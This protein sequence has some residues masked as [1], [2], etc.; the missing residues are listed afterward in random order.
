[1]NVQKCAVRGKRSGRQMAV[2]AALLLVL[3][4]IAPAAQAVESAWGSDLYGG[5]FGPAPTGVLSSAVS[6]QVR[7][8]GW[9]PQT[10]TNTK[11]D[12]PGESRV[13]FSNLSVDPKS[14]IPEA[15]FSLT[16]LRT[17][18]F[19]IGYW[20]STQEGRTTLSNAITFDG[21]TFPSSTAVKSTVE[22]SV[23]KLGYEYVLDGEWLRLGFGF[24]ADF[25]STQEQIKQQ[26]GGLQGKLDDSLVVPFVSGEAAVLFAGWEIFA[27]IDLIHYG[28]AYL[29]DGRAGISYGYDL[30]P[31]V[32]TFSIGGGADWRIWDVMVDN[33]KQNAEW[34]QQGLELFVFL[35][36]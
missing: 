23:V 13:N 32:A 28:S 17:H 18:K 8:G 31:G 12:N 25:I 26:G 24:G 1:M 9:L 2:L 16:L 15:D 36:F 22:L 34:T 30:P 11:A 10:R 6:F 33:S 35:R 14:V 27:N 7:V 19:R 5:L 4:S 20:N 29:F 21:T 3:A